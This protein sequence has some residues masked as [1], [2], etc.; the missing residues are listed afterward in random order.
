MDLLLF[1][2]VTQKKF[3]LFGLKPA[4]LRQRCSNII[5]I[6]LKTSRVSAVYYPASF[7]GGVDGTKVRTTEQQE[8]M[9]QRE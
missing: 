7:W 5:S 9:E 8:E 1:Q 6:G 3:R 2:L 4:G